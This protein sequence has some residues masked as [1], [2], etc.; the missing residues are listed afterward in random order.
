MGSGSASPRQTASTI[1]MCACIEVTSVFPFAE[2][3]VAAADTRMTSRIRQW[4]CR[5]FAEVALRRGTVRVPTTLV[6]GE[7]SF[8]VNDDDATEFARIAPGFQQAIVVPDAGHSVQGDQPRALVEILRSV[9][10]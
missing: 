7:K 2:S 6:R 1:A 3:R 5:S 4:E 9:L 10:E 8:F